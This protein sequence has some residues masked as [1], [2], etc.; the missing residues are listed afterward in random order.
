MYTIM[1]HNFT[2]AKRQKLLLGAG[3]MTLSRQN[4]VG[5]YFNVE[6]F[7]VWIIKCRKPSKM[8]GCP[9]HVYEVSY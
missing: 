7:L 6:R 3:D 2:F 1:K 8:H 9:E 5:N 4:N